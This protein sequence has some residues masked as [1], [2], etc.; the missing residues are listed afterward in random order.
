MYLLEALSLWVETLR[1]LVTNECTP[2]PP[3]LADVQDLY[4]IE[5]DPSN[6]DHY[7]VDGVSL[8]YSHRAEVIKVAGADDLTIDIRETIH[9]PVVSDRATSG[10]GIVN[11]ALVDSGVVFALRWVSIDAS[12]TDTTFAAFY[13]L[14]KAAT[15]VDF[16]RALSNWTAPSQNVVYAD[17]KGNVGYQMPGWI[18]TRDLS[19]GYTGAWPVPGNA[20]AYSWRT[21][22]SFDNLPRVYNPARGFVATANNQVPPNS[23]TFN[24]TLFLSADWDEGS[25][26]YRAKRI[27]E[28]INASGTANTV[29]SVT[30]TQT[31]YTSLF[32][33]DMARTLAAV[34]DADVTTDA[35]RS[36]RDALAAWSGECSVGSTLASVWAAMLVALSQLGAPETGGAWGDPV[37]LLNALAPGS[38]DPACALSPPYTTCAAFAGAAL[39]AV[40]ARYG[41]SPAAPTGSAPAWGNDVHRVLVSHQVLSSSVL[42]C[43]A[44]RVVAHGGDAHTVNVGGFALDND[45]DANGAGQW[46]QHAGP[47]VRH[48][49]DLGDAVT[50]GESRW[51]MPMGNDGDILSPQYDTLL[52]RWARGEYLLMQRSE[53]DGGPELSLQP[54]GR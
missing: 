12:I 28:L 1:A 25:D 11:A 6:P 15:W 34:T 46:A 19:I 10:T 30:H 31:D 53:G 45:M 48:V 43:V 16:R 40:G 41:A 8:P 44:D 9:G 49:M 3:R 5:D 47:S 2:H 4:V 27:T 13:G 35:G 36:V 51:I 33:R 37:F 50:G 29:E 32:A 52:S 22:W 42:A 18:P 14:Q 17:R 38:A 26:G 23:T 20:S 39:D 24:S 7:K 54:V 21:P